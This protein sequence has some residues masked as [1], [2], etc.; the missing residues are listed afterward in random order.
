[1]KN[2]RVFQLNLDSDWGWAKILSLLRTSR[3]RD[4]AGIG[5]RVHSSEIKLQARKQWKNER[6]RGKN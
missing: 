5:T 2:A 1:M 6:E 4:F 3:C